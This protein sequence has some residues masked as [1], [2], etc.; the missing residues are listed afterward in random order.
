MPNRQTGVCATETATFG[1]EKGLVANQ[2]HL[3]IT[4]LGGLKR[5]LNGWG[6]SMVTAHDIKRNLHSG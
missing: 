3:D 6:W 2:E 1:G 5:P 4:F